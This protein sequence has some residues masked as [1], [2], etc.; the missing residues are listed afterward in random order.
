[1]MRERRLNAR[2]SRDWVLYA[3]IIKERGG[4]ISFGD[5]LQQLGSWPGRDNRRQRVGQILGRNKRRGFQKVEQYREGETY[6]SVW[7]FTGELPEIPRRTLR[8][9]DEKLGTQ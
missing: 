8:D 9:W 7:A 5:L 1:M 6:V 2:K 3:Y 4:E